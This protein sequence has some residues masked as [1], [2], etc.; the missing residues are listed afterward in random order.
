MLNHEEDFVLRESVSE[1]SLNVRPA[2]NL[3]ITRRP[4]SSIRAPRCSIGRRAPACPPGHEA[5]AASYRCDPTP[6]EPKRKTRR[7]RLQTTAQGAF[8]SISLPLLPHPLHTHPTAQ[9][10]TRASSLAPSL[11]LSLS[12]ALSLNLSISL[13]SGYLILSI[14]IYLSI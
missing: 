12:F 5:R 3:I 11:P 2:P 1:M 6:A 9:I 7:L 10:H 13:L 4:R 8:R 14:Y